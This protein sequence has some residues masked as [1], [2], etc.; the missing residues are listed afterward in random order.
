MFEGPP[1]KNWTCGLQYQKKM[2]TAGLFL[3]VRYA[4]AGCQHC[5]YP[6]P[7][8]I[9]DVNDWYGTLKNM[10]KSSLDR[11]GYKGGVFDTP[12]LQWTQHAYIQ[13]QMHPYDRFFYDP[14]KGYTVDRFL[15]GLV[16][17]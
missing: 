13:P 16:Y 15:K 1:K 14:V 7:E 10:R 5:T 4:T 2:I 3:L 11:I 6:P 12:E 8:T 9:S 17:L